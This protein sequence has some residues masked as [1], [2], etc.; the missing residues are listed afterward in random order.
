MG[1]NILVAE[2]RPTPIPAKNRPATKSGIALA[3]VWRITPKENTQLLI[4]IASRRPKISATGAA[5]SAPKKVPAESR[6]TIIED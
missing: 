4:I 3:A 1:A 6:E 5:N 2:R